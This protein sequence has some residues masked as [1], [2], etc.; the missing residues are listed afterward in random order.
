MALKPSETDGRTELGRR[1]K[2]QTRARIVAAAFE[3]FGEENG[4]FARIEDIAEIAGVTRATFYNHFSGLVDLRDAVTHEVT[5]DFL[6]AVTN[7][8]LQLT[9]LRER[10]TAAVRFYL[11]RARQDPKWGWSMMNMSASGAIFGAETYR[12][13]EETVRDGILA[14]ELPIRSA[15]LGRDILLGASHAAMASLLRQEMPEDYPEAVAGHILISLGVPYEDAR[16]ISHLPMP[17]LTAPGAGD[18]PV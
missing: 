14:G 9:D 15:E 16:Q 3:V 10:C 18:S 5:H 1:R 13:A 4:L 2:A 11:H 8:V 17:E 7:T 12:Q 6:L